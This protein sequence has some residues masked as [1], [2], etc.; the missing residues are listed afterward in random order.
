MST[1]FSSAAIPNAPTIGTAT[2]TS[3]VAATVTYTAAVLG[4]TGTTFTATSNPSSITGTGSSPITVTGLTAST[5][6][7]FTVTAGNANGTSAASSASNSITTNAPSGSYESIATAT[8]GSGGETSITFSSIPATY[9]HL[10]LRYLV[11]DARSNGF[12]SPVDLTF[13]GSNATAYAK[14]F[15]QGEG[16]SASGGNETSKT[17]MR[18]EGAG[19]NTQSSAF[20]AAITDILDYTS[21]SKNK[22][23]KHLS[24]VDKNGSGMVRFV[25]GLWYATPAAITSITLTP[26]SS[27][28]AQY[29]HFALYGIKGE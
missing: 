6:Y 11:R 21:T 2:A 12:D 29:S 8:V 22:T 10:Q 16:S 1:G 14:H 4:A 25:S 24:G 5:S 15:I 7:T 20:G 9:K 26:F 17:Y 28:F 19:N 27:P 23:V 13:N 3:D 18:L